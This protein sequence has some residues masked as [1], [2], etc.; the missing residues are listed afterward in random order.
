[1]NLNRSNS[2]QLDWIAVIIF[3]ALTFLQ[4]VKNLDY[5]LIFCLPQ[6]PESLHHTLTLLNHMEN[7]YCS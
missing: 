3:T 6:T 7:N 4:K 2:F 5:I 1:M